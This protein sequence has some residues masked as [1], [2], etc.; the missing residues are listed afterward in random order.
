MSLNTKLGGLRSIL[1]FDNRWQ[2]VIQ[3]LFFWRTPLYVYRT[4]GMQILIDHP[5][6]DV[7]GLRECFDTP[8]YEQFLKHMNL[9]PPLNVLDLGA[10]I[11]AFALMLQASGRELARLVGVELNPATF[12]R[13]QFNI[14]RNLPR[15]ETTLIN[16][17]IAGQSGQASF[18]FGGGS[19]SD[20]LVRQTGP[21]TNG[22]VSVERRV[23]LITVDDAL[24]RAGMGQGLIDLCK[25]DIEGAEY[26]VFSN[27]GH[28]GLS[29]CRYILIE[30]HP[31]EGH[32]PNEVITALESMGF[33][34]TEGSPDREG[35]IY[36]FANRKLE[37][38]AVT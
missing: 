37:S 11:G 2:L 4:A 7:C 18:H 28:S 19:T 34:Q 17:G 1:R 31:L 38:T 23:N 10:H 3:R 35:N 26:Q 22:P 33:A 36:C 9:K 30:I 12:S 14:E 20:S 27:P 21:S 16:A 29:R 13:M 25:M 24:E 15:T 8:M 6:G 32:G 5:R